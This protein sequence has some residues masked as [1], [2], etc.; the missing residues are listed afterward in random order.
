VT[1]S[2]QRSQEFL[3]PYWHCHA[4][5][6]NREA[7][8]TAMATQDALA[9]TSNLPGSQSTAAV[10]GA[11]AGMPPQLA[12]YQ[13]WPA[14]SL[15]GC[16]HRFVRQEALEPSERM[17]CARYHFCAGAGSDCLGSLW[18]VVAGGFWRGAH[19]CKACSLGM[20][21][22]QTTSCLNIQ[23]GETPSAFLE[24]PRSSTCSPPAPLS[25]AA[26]GASLG[27]L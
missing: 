8:D 14:A 19:C 12:G 10:L 16:L 15:A 9:A 21:Q 22:L 27:M 5:G 23:I 7:S 25:A 26:A 4:A 6:P 11:G 3:R 2:S 18:F 13:R 17:Q 1:N 20:L 24:I